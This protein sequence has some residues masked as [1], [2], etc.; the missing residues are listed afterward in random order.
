M[1]TRFRNLSLWPVVA[2]LALAWF[3]AA[4]AEPGRY[5]EL[6]A[7][8]AEVLETVPSQPET[9]LVDAAL[10]ERIEAILGHRFARLRLRYWSDGKTTA[11]TLDEV[12]KTEPITIGVAVREG[13]VTS[14]RILEF[15]ESRGW[16]VRYP[17]FTDQFA[18]LGLD[19]DDRIDGSIDGITGATLS[20][21][22][23]E[24]SVRVALAFD[25]HIRDAG[26]ANSS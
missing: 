5:V 25:G 9:L 14:V 24:K 22:A 16:E 21:A 17:F 20:V 3:V 26:R 18:G 2:V 8:L 1:T 19:A 4:R 12:G 11:W 13:R 7:F 6:D 10:R 15:R 23:V